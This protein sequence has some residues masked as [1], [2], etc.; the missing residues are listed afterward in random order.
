MHALSTSVLIPSWRRPETLMQCL[1]SL[2]A[3]TTSPGEVL[4]VWQGDD[5]STRD[6]A[7]ALASEAAFPLHVLHLAKPGIVPAENLALDAA[8]G[9]LILLIDDDAVAPPDWITRHLAH[10]ADPTVGAVGG[11]AVNYWPDGTPYPEHPLEP[12][13]T[14]SWFGRLRGN[15]FDQPE[16]WRTRAPREVDHVVGYNF[17]LRRHVFRHF[18]EQLQRYWQLWELEACLQV[19]GSGHRVLFDFQNVVE[20]HPTNTAYYG[21]RH[22]DL[23]VKIYGGAFNQCFVLAKHSPAHLRPVRLVFQLFVGSVSMPGLVGAVVATRRFGQPLRE[24]RVLART[25]QSSLQ[26]WR[27]GAGRR[28]SG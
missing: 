17:S 21:G 8:Q 11:P 14:L 9:E 16:S 15:M 1:R 3:Q 5:T 13:G 18:E 19:R 2:M 25:L 20:H 6:A 7:L 24:L 26:G 28:K 27:A 23:D 22:G 4:V 12:I 10:Y